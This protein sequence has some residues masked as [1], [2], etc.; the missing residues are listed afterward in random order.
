MKVL[1][2]CKGCG[3]IVGENEIGCKC[4]KCDTLLIRSNI[5]QEA[6]EPTTIQTGHDLFKRPYKKMIKGVKNRSSNG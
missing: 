5:T 2:Y 4:R 3:L 6:P 1:G